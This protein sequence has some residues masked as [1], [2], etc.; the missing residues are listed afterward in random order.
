MAQAL[1]LLRSPV[2]NTAATFLFSSCGLLFMVSPPSLTPTL[3]CFCY[4]DHSNYITG[5]TCMAS[6]SISLI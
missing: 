6:I 2:R 4:Q 3:L 1:L 5:A